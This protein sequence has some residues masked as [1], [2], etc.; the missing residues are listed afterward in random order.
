MRRAGQATRTY[1]EPLWRRLHQA[2]LNWRR[3]DGL[4]DVLSTALCRHTVLFALRAFGRVGA[5]GWRPV[6]GRIGQRAMRRVPDY[7]AGASFA[8]HCWLGHPF[9]LWLDLTGDQFGFPSVICAPATSGGFAGH[10]PVAGR[11]PLRSLLRTIHNWE[12]DPKGTWDAR[13]LART[14]EAYVAY[15]ARMRWILRP[16]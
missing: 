9:G 8:D 3:I 2:D 14:R 4:P 13:D 1:L 12:G 11:P 15:L 10:E 5:A 7:A 6:N 16:S